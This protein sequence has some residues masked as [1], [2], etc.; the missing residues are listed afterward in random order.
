M[1]QKIGR[2]QILRELGQGGM[3]SVYLAQDPYLGRPV[4]VKVLAHELTEDSLFLAFFQREAEIIAALE[5]PAIVP[6]FDFGIH[7]C[8]PYIVMRYMAGGSLQERLA[9][10]QLPPRRLARIL[11]RVA[12]GLQA[13]HARGIV[14]RDLKP[15]NILFDE[16]EQAYVADFGLARLLS[17]PTGAT[18]QFLIGTPAYMSP[19]QTR[20]HAVDGR[21]DVYAMGV[22]LYEALTGTLPYCHED[23]LETAVMHIQSPIPSLLTHRPDLSQTWENILHKALAKTPAQRHP[24]PCQLARDVSDAAIGLGFWHKLRET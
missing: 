8:Q 5:H 17:R 3:A 12:G 9:D 19:E 14:H 22:I 7:G 4:A 21:S 2:Y 15:A 1:S 16:T 13:A 10:G 23:A 11:E 18:G 20:G 24:S 6:I